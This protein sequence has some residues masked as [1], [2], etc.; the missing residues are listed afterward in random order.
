M[1]DEKPMPK[2][3]KAETAAN[4]L[5]LGQLLHQYSYPIGDLGLTRPIRPEEAERFRGEIQAL[6]KRVEEAVHDLRQW[7][8]RGILGLRGQEVVDSLAVRIVSYVAWAN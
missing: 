4:L 7:V 3:T 5:R 6:E 1:A 8:L 2:P